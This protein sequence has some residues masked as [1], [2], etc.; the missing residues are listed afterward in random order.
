MLLALVYASIA[1]L[2][3]F[4]SCSFALLIYNNDAN[5]SNP[6]AARFWTG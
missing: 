5:V 2:V 1:L 3:E 4:S 6:S